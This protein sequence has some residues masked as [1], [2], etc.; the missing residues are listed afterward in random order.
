VPDHGLTAPMKS[1]SWISNPM[2]CCNGC[3]TA[4]SMC[5]RKRAIALENFFRKGNLIALRE[6]ALRKTADR[7]DAALRANIAANSRSIRRG[8]RRSACWWHSVRAAMAS[9]WLRVGKRLAPTAL[10]ARWLAVSVETSCLLRLPERD[11]NRRIKWLRLAESL[12]AETVTR[13]PRGGR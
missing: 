4:R 6:L 8:P 9:R 7:V 3:A 1:N 10:H 5:R 12:G 13:A 11:A 2:S